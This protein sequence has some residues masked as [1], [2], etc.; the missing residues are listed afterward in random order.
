MNFYGGA[1]DHAGIDP[2]GQLVQIGPNGLFRVVFRSEVSDRLLSCALLI[3]IFIASRN[4][5]GDLL[6]CALIA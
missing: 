1:V 2:C 3:V 5:D 6:G 4:W